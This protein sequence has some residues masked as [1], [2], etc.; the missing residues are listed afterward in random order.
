M[1]SLAS[2]E[3][4]KLLHDHKSIPKSSPPSSVWQPFQESVGVTHIFYTL[5]GRSGLISS[6][7]DFCFSSSSLHPETN[8]SYLSWLMPNSCKAH[9]SQGQVCSD[10]GH[11]SS[12]PIMELHI[13]FCLLEHCMCQ[14][15]WKDLQRHSHRW[16]SYL[17]VF[18][19]HLYNQ[20]VTLV[21]WKFKF[22]DCS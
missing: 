3:E 10:V 18:F 12:I 19:M 14:I 21:L 11:K 20:Y 7:L 2:D 9:S 8:S 1:A 15:C 22:L 4:T 16:I 5:Y 6:C 17:C 13:R